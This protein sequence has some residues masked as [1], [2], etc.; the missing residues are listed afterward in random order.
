[1]SELPNGWAKVALE[2]LGT[3]G[4]GGTPKRTDSRFYSGG[5]I[6][7]LVIGDLT[8]GVVTHARTYITEDGLLNSSAKLLPPN[9]LLIAM[10]GSIGKLGITEIE[11]ATNQAIAFCLPDREIIE[12]RYL[13][14]A[15]Q[16][17]RDKLAIQGQGVAQKNISQTI[18]KAHQIPVAPQKEQKR[19]ADKLDSLLARVDACRDRLERVSHILERFRQAVITTAISGEL[20]EDWRITSDLTEWQSVTL[21]EICLS[22]TD[23]DHQA[24]PQVK[25][26]IPFITIAA[27]NDRRLNLDKVTRFVPHSYFDELK[28]SRKPEVGDIL[29]SVTGSIAIPALVNTREKFTFQRHIAILKPDSSRMLSKFLFY[30]LCTEDIKR[31]AIAVATGTA[32]KTIPLSGLREFMIVL[33]PIDEQQEVIHRLNKLFTYA[34]HIEVHYQNACKQVE[35][36]TSALLSKAFRGELVPQDPDDEPAT[37]LL[38]HIRAKRAEQAAQPKRTFKR[39]PTMIKITKAS[40]KEVIDQWPQDTFSFDELYEKISGNYDL[41]KDI[42]FILLSEPEPIITQIFDRKAKSIRFVRGNQ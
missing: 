5:T 3:W 11:C 42:L 4:S 7:W 33:P 28:D 22:I 19:I 25:H 23:G 41:L 31:Q 24:P 12:L 32:Q 20:T 16:Y 26:G 30:S 9:T 36:I 2:E 38:E 29:F 15:L 18:L 39:K 37:V 21:S 14:H 27:I 35:Q 1:M 17:S 8:D 34:N 10:Y 13:F 6:P 40:V